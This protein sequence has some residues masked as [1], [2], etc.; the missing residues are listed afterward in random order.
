MLGGISLINFLKLY[1]YPDK[2]IVEVYGIYTNLAVIE[3]VKDLL[4]SSAPYMHY[5]IDHIINIDKSKTGLDTL[6][7]VLREPKLF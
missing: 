3:S 7:I 5:K 2:E 1:R 6:K 4:K